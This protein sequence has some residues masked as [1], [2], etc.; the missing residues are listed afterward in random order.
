MRVE[1]VKVTPGLKCKVGKNKKKQ[2]SRR[3][4]RCITGVA[5]VGNGDFSSTGTSKKCREGSQTSPCRG[6][7][8][9]SLKAPTDTPIG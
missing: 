2:K 8:W 5:A 4:A 6:S 3:G 9:G 7:M 1:E